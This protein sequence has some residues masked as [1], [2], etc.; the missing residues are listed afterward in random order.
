MDLDILHRALILINDHQ[1]DHWLKVMTIEDKLDLATT[2]LNAVQ[3][4]IQRLYQDLRQEATVCVFWFFPCV[5]FLIKDLFRF[6]N[7][8]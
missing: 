4:K 2:A 5:F 8:G 6:L 1:G 7:I 3:P